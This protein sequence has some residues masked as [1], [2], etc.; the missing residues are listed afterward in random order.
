MLLLQEMCPVLHYKVQ[1]LTHCCAVLS[2]LHL[3]QTTT[4]AAAIITQ[5]QRMI[6]HLHEQLC[7]ATAAAQQMHMQLLT[8][9]EQ[10][11]KAIDAAA[12]AQTEAAELRALLV[13]ERDDGHN[14]CEE[15]RYVTSELAATEKKLAAALLAAK[16][17]PKPV[18]AANTV[19][20]NIAVN[21]RVSL[22]VTP[23]TML[24]LFQP[25]RFMYDRMW[26]T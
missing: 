16:Q 24:N 23:L 1:S 9:Q 6:Q 26:S 4:A 19:T 18:A 13:S 17:T 20:E 3:L 25:M 8:S 2:H 11:A 5:Q 7:T 21:T 14:S 10:R 22:N 15:L 12:T